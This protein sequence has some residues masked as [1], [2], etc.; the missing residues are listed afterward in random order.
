MELYM[1]T[2]IEGGYTEIGVEVYGQSSQ[3]VHCKK[4]LKPFVYF[5]D[6][7]FGD[8]FNFFLCVGAIYHRHTC[9]TRGGHCNTSRT[10]SRVVVE[11]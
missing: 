11:G 2:N 3:G 10:Q 6:N 9:P 7:F 4:N 8:I 1:E 5:V